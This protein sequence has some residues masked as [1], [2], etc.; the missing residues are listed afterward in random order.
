MSISPHGP[1]TT[2]ESQPGC[3]HLGNG[4]Q[5]LR[6]SLARQRLE[7]DVRQ[8][9]NVFDERVGCIRQGLRDLILRED[10]RGR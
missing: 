6:R 7:I 1:P 2:S 8:P 4:F 10:G 3:N 5:G 9:V